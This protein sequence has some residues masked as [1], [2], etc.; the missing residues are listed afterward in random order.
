M[1]RD[2]A[3]AAAATAGRWALDHKKKLIT[4]AIAIALWVAQGRPMPDAALMGKALAIVN[5]LAPILE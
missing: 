1:N 2:Q 3:L 4:A 5:V